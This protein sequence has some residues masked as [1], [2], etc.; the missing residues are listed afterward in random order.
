VT[1]AKVAAR[2]EALEQRYGLTPGARRQL[3]GVLMH[4]A[5]DAT[6]PTTVRDPERAL[7]V[8]LADSLVG[9]ELEAVR[10]AGDIADVGAGAGFPGLALAAALP[11][12]RVWLVESATRK[13]R[14]L[15][16]VVRDAGIANASVV[17]AR[18]EEWD[19]GRG[20]HDLVVARALASL[21]VIAEYAAPLLTLGGSLVAW[22]GR[23]DSG[24]EE[25]GMRAAVELGLEPHPP[26]AVDPFP[27][28]D[29]RHLYVYEKVAPT[30]ARFP[31]RPGRAASRPLA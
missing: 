11:D 24:E 9:L 28:A 22:K 26:V 25:R 10:A 1:S 6:A 21:P 27:E 8:H 13:C 31:R 19:V 20:A 16:G 14:Y 15:E 7:D 4:M 3:E 18:V 23:R 29:N 12:A 17:H 5:F 2:W 30:P